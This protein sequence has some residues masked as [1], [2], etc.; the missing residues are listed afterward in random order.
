MVSPVPRWKNAAVGRSTMKPLIMGV[1][2]RRSRIG[3]WRGRSLPFPFA[4]FKAD[5]RKSGFFLVIRLVKLLGG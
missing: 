5:R 2:E 3:L 1:A 4:V